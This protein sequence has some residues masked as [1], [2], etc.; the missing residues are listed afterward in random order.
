[1]KYS[2]HCGVCSVDIAIISITVF[3]GH[4]KCRNQMLK[5]AINDV[6]ETVFIPLQWACCKVQQDGHQE[7]LKDV[8][9]VD[10]SVSCFS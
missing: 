7:G 1:V 2:E 9:I 6:I 4:L 3:K 5:L 8:Y 10:S